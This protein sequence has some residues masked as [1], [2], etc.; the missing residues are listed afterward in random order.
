ME[1]KSKPKE[2]PKLPKE[3]PLETVQIELEKEAGI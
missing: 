3:S 2:K 1:E